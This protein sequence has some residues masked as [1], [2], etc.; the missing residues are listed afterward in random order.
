MNRAVIV[1]YR[2]CILCVAKESAF[3]YAVA[4]HL[5]QMNMNDFLKKSNSGSVHQVPHR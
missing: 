5:K 1:S 4:G 2:S 3:E